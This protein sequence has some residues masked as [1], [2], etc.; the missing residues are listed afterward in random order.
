MF[1]QFPSCS[2]LLFHCYLLRRLFLSS[3]EIFGTFVKNQLTIY[4]WVYFWSISSVPLV[5]LSVLCHYHNLLF[6]L[7]VFFFFD[8]LTTCRILVFQ[9][10]IEPAPL[11]MKV[12]VSN[13]WTTREYA[14]PYCFDFCSIFFF[15]G[16]Y[17]AAEGLSSGTCNLIFWPGIEPRPP[18]LGAQNLSCWTTRED[19][20]FTEHLVCCLLSIC[21]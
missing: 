8:C 15:F 11:A 1:V 10:G 4:M 21:S 14:Q 3:I 7:F 19:S 20:T 6:Y 17:L 16:H 12:W 9:P 2:I 5:F 13:H 18:T